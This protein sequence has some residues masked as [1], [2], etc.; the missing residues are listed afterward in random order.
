MSARE[1]KALTRRYFEEI[2]KGAVGVIDEFISPNIVA[3]NPPPGV[4]PN[5]EG[6]K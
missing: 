1:N 3:H 5:I 6:F 2:D 4:S